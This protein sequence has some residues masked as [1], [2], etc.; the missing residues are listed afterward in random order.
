[1]KKAST[2]HCPKCKHIMAQIKHEETTIDRCVHCNG[3]WFDHM[4][5]EQLQ[6]LKGSEIIDHGKSKTGG[7]YDTIKDISCPRCNIPM[8]MNKAPDKDHFTYETCSQCN[9]VFLDA[10]EFKEFKTEKS[11]L[12]LLKK[13]LNK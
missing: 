11:I 7:K 12:D 13:L 10:G 6:R 2:M 4:E 3:I 9:G 8:D 5:M 1:M